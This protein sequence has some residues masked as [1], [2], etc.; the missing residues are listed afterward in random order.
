MSS[1]EH[2]R[3]EQ[4]L[5]GGTVLDQ[6]RTRPLVI[7]RRTTI[8]Q[9]ALVAPVPS[10]FLISEPP[11]A[12]QGQSSAGNGTGLALRSREKGL[13]WQNERSW[14]QTATLAGTRGQHSWSKAT[15]WLAFLRRAPP[16]PT[17]IAPVPPLLPL[18][19]KVSLNT[20]KTVPSL[21]HI[22]RDN[23]VLSSV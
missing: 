14:R 10:S 12:Q 4:L 8:P 20:L 17:P 9:Q 16:A 22:I 5:R 1:A 2:E 18:Q 19:L 13:F 21:L 7:T 11:S 3:E 6:T 15:T 23:A